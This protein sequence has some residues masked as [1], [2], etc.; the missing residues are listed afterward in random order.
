ML[1]WGENKNETINNKKVLPKKK[2]KKFCRNLLLWLLHWV[3]VTG[4]NYKWWCFCSINKLFYQGNLLG[5]MY[6]KWNCIIPNPRE[7]KEEV[8]N[9][10]FWTDAFS[11]TILLEFLTSEHP[12]IFLISQVIPVWCS[13]THKNQSTIMAYILYIPHTEKI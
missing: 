12:W 3:V 6:K 5:Y 13:I 10:G 9:F 11:F 1:K 7:Y 8:S 2:K 4:I